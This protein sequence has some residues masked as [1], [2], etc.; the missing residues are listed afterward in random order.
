MGNRTTHQA[1][2]TP[3][4]TGLRNMAYDPWK[5]IKEMWAVGSGAYRLGAGAYR[6]ANGAAQLGSAIAQSREKAPEIRE[7]IDPMA[8]LASAEELGPYQYD[9]DGF[10]LGRI[11]SDHGVNF[12]ACMPASDDRHVFIVAGSASGKGISFGIQNGLRWRG[13]LLAID[14]KAELAE[15]TA[16]HRGSRENALGS[17]TSVRRFKGQKVGILDPMNIVRGPAKKYRVNY[18]PL[19]EI[20]IGTRPAHNKIAKLA[21]GMIVPEEG[22]GAH[23]SQSAET[24]LAGTIEAVLTIETDPAN[25]SLPFLRKKIL[26]NV[27][28]EQV[29]E[30]AAAAGFEALYDYLTDDCLPDDGH[31]AEAASV[32]GEV[33]GSDE[34]GSFRTTLSRNLKWIGDPDIRDHLQPS[35][36]SL[37]KAVQEGWSIYLVLKPDDIAGF[38]N[39]LRMLV[40]LALSA[41]MDMGT[42]QTGPQTLF[43]LDEFSALGR[44]KEIEDAAGYMRGYGIKL[45]PIIQNV[46]QIQNIYRKNWE[47]FLGNA[48]AVIS[49][50]L[51]DLESEKY[52]SDRLGR[53]VVPETSYSET[54]S[55]AGFSGN[56]SRNM[57][58]SLRERSVRFPNE[59]H[60]QGARETMRAFVI[61]ASGRAFTIERI[62]YMRIARQQLYDS[63]DHIREWERQY[64]G[65]RNGR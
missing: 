22:S 46:G 44:F 2:A 55:T 24:L 42:N 10:Y 9:K 13:P 53:I 30:K 63:P 20:K 48:G 51:N 4:A 45:C 60:E 29:N 54:S 14:P 16:I 11:H 1:K 19:S 8:G 25:H 41:K 23:F 15:L 35:G 47:T 7:Q 49:W 40:Q 52:I 61:P 18:N 62:P 65:N 39:W 26:G 38:R 58:T 21:A 56:R 28:L 50:S 32:L 27:K 6:F 34:A 36:F 43:F 37:W 17:G 57:N 31:A 33:L 5:P 64:G 59:V 3:K 12:E